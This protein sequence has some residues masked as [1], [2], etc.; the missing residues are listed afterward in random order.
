MVNTH[1]FINDTADLA[2]YSLEHYGEVK[3]IA[4]CHLIYKKTGKY[5]NKDKSVNKKAYEI[6]SNIH[7]IKSKW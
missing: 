4:D 6:I 3:D 1:Y 7:I 5:Y 2:A